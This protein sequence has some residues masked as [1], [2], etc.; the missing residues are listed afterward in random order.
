MPRLQLPHFGK[1]LPAN[2]HTLCA[3]VMEH[4]ALGRVG[5]AGHVPLQTDALLFGGRVL[6]RDRGEERLRVGVEGTAVNRF[7]P[8]RFHNAAQI[9]HA[10]AVADMPHHVKIVGN[11]Q[12][13]E[14]QVPLKPHEK[15]ENLRL[16]GDVQRGDR[17]VRHHEARLADQR[18]GNTDALPL[19]ARKLV[20]VALQLFLRQS[21]GV[22]HPGNR[23][24]QLRPGVA[25]EMGVQRLLQQSP[26]RHARIQGGVGI[27]KDKLHVPPLLPQHFPVQRAEI[28]APKIN[29]PGGRLDEPQQRAPRG[30]FSAAGF[31]HQGEGFLFINLKAHVLH[32]MHMA[33]GA[34][35]DAALDGK[36][37][38][39]VLN[40]QNRLLLRHSNA[41]PSARSAW[42]Q[43]RHRCPGAA[44]RSGGFL[45][46]QMGMQWSQRSANRQP[47]PKAPA[48]G[49]IPRMA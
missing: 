15:V 25:G 9:H 38:P 26:H 49:T 7:R 14:L 39:Q 8:S 29:I 46:L 17:L 22:S 18:A 47:A 34:P 36:I 11:E 12:I 1:L 19:P 3:A 30:G 32:G 23:L 37:G 4:T 20:R 24:V 33:H 48:V 16:N 45:A 42:S 10:D 13:G 41:S 31:T 5:G 43:Q 2:F 6:L 40:L 35:D 21:H 28:V 27:L 44:S